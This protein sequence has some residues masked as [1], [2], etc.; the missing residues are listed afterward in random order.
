MIPEV[1]PHELAIT[2]LLLHEI[3]YQGRGGVPLLTSAHILVVDGAQYLCK[4]LPDEICIYCAIH[5]GSF[6]T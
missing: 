4:L 5:V 6:L 3:R 2:R 1:Q